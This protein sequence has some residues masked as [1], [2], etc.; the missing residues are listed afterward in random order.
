[1]VRWPNLLLAST[2]LLAFLLPAPLFSQGADPLSSQVVIT[3]L[4]NS[5]DTGR[6]HNGSPVLTRVKY[7]WSDGECRL[8]TGTTIV[9]HVA[10][11][12]RHSKQDKDSSMTIVFDKTSCSGSSDRS[13]AL[14]LY[15]LVGSVT[16][17]DPEMAERDGLFGL[18]STRAQFGESADTPG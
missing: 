10:D 17:T 9:G 8:R 6:L 5:L 1:M 3:E 12:V 14:V 15:A 11:V 2:L 7:E 16:M 18:S 4:L 13:V